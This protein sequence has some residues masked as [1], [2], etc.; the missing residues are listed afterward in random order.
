[1]ARKKKHHKAGEQVVLKGKFRGVIEEAGAKKPRTAAQKRADAAGAK[2]FKALHAKEETTTA[3]KS[4]KKPAKAKKPAKRKRKKAKGKRSTAPAARATSMSKHTGHKRSKKG[5][6]RKVSASQKKAYAKA[7]SSLRARAGAA[8]LSTGAKKGRK[9]GGKRGTKKAAHVGV[10]TVAEVTKT[11]RAGTKATK[12]GAKKGAKRSK[13]H[14]LFVSER[15]QEALAKA[16]AAHGRKKSFRAN[17]AS[18][19][20]S[21]SGGGA[22]TGASLTSSLLPN[23]GGS[24]VVS[25]GRVAK[26]TGGAHHKSRFTPAQLRAREKKQREREKAAKKRMMAAA[27]AAGKRAKKALKDLVPSSARSTR[28]G[29]PPSSSSAT[30]L[31]MG[32]LDTTIM[33]EV[34]PRTLASLENLLGGTSEGPATMRSAAPTLRGAYGIPSIKTG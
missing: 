3:K 24:V 26:L 16:F 14:K 10:M 6:T 20:K 32:T 31:R 28:R 29:A 30:T 34:S 33:P 9:K 13:S 11:K 2:R 15:Q 7:A 12:K 1:M 8:P 21:L 4:S 17:F 18:L 27:K 23:Y 5:A 22:F 25:G 19:G